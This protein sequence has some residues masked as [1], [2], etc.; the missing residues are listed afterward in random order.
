MSQT[1]KIVKR[2]CK[3]CSIP[4]KIIA[5]N[6][7][8]NTTARSIKTMKILSCK[9]LRSNW[10][11]TMRMVDANRKF[12][13]NGRGSDTPK[14]E[15]KN[16]RSNVQRGDDDEELNSYWVTPYTPCCARFFAIAICI[17][18]SSRA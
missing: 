11:I 10:N 1:Y 7:V 5:G 15:Y 3:R 12:K 9:T 18:A 8:K 16:A 14:I 17:Y 6:G 2:I 13:I 4:E